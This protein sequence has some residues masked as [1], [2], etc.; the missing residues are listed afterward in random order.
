MSKYELTI[1]PDYVKDWKFED[2]IRELHQNA[3][4]QEVRD[5]NN[6]FTHKYEGEAITITSKV[7]VLE[8]SSL[9]LGT[10]SKGKD[11]KTVGKYGEGYK[12]AL[13]VLV[14]LGFPVKIYNYAAKEIW[15]PKIVKS[16]RYGCD[17]LSIDVKKHIFTSVPD[18]NLTF[19]VHNVKPINYQSVIQT[20]LPLQQYE[21][22]DT[23]F[24]E[25][26]TSENHRG[27]IFVNGLF[28]SKCENNKVRFGYNLKPEFLSLD[29]DRRLIDTFNLTWM[30]SNLWSKYDDAE[31]VANLIMEEVP[32]VQ[33]IDSFM[34]TYKGADT[35]ADV[36]FDKL[37]SKHG[38]NSIPAEDQYQADNIS[39]EFRGV[40]PIVYPKQGKIVRKFSKNFDTHM[41]YVKAKPESFRTKTLIN[42][43]KMEL[44]AE[45][46][47]RE[48]Y[49]QGDEETWITY[50]SEDVAI[51]INICKDKLSN[52]ERILSNG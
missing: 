49:E 46:L 52:I 17:I 13:L 20:F 37:Q 1:S 19:A 43:S 8:K 30:T 50:G 47:K 23:T 35:V 45:L 9:L 6:K 32:D 51:S 3:I 44:L 16:R 28:V 41:S 21:K 39:D 31:F 38:L 42:A 22:I 33:Y 34:T 7:S 18:S 40:K 36:L 12:L 11:S 26:L 14:R 27:Q 2:A 25:V 24:G 4:D 15:V 5:P 48:K 10:T 29:R